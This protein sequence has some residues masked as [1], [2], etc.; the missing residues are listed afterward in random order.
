MIKKKW[1]TLDPAF[2]R[3]GKNEHSANFTGLMDTIQ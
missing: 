2:M 1:L 3:A